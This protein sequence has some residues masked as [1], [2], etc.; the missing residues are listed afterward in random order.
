M[1]SHDMSLPESAVLLKNRKLVQLF[2]CKC[3]C[4]DF[5]L[6]SMIV[7]SWTDWKTVQI[8]IMM[9]D[10]LKGKKQHHKVS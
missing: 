5:A 9:G 2:P 1:T 8:S 6:I 10:R 7:K 3:K 4:F